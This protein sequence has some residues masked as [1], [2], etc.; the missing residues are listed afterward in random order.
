MQKKKKEAEALQDKQYSY[1]TDRSISD[2]ERFVMY[3]N[4]CE[5]SEFITVQQLNNL[6]KNDF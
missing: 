5:G 3:V 1:L 2:L 6:L 4:D